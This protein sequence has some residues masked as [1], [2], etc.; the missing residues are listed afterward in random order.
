MTGTLSRSQATDHAS[1]PDSSAA[2]F[3]ALLRQHRGIVLKV[4]NS[5]AHGAEDRADLVQDIA[6]QL[7]RAWPAYDPARRYST[8]MYRIALN[9]AISWLR[10]ERLRRH[11]AV[12]L[13]ECVHDCADAGVASPEDAERVRLLWRFMDTLDPLNRALLVLYLEQ[14]S[15]REMAEILG[16]GESSVT[17]RISRLKQRLRDWAGDR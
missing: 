4:A 12:P 14:R 2:R 5:Y 10:G 15:T 8:W 3:D 7:W 6:T 13:E 11:H 1:M 9:T 16:L 17:T